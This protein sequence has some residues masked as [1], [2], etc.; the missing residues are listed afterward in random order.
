MKGRERGR[1][2]D[3]PVIASLPCDAIDPPVEEERERGERQ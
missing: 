1:D 3:S 2:H